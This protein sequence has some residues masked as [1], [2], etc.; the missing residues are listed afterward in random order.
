AGTTC[1]SSNRG[2]D[3]SA[4]TTGNPGAGMPRGPLDSNST[5]DPK[6]IR[7]G[8][9]FGWEAAAGRTS[10]CSFPYVVIH[11]QHLVRNAVPGKGA[12]DANSSIASHPPAPFEVREQRSETPGYR[13]RI[14][15]HFQPVDLMPDDFLWPSINCRNHRLARA[16]SLE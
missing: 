4:A 3:A 8:V 15:M 13:I 5:T 6:P 12:L 11:A 2:C 10:S 7:S 9:R 1:S 14:W 16:P